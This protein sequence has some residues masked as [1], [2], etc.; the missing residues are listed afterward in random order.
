MNEQLKYQNGFHNHFSTEALPGALP[1][2]QNSPQRCAY[3]LYAEQLTGSAFTAPR[4]QN[5]RSWL[6]RIRPSVVQSAYQPLEN[7]NV[8]TAPL[9]K[10][11]ADPNQMRWDPV[12][13][14]NEPTDFIDGLFTI[15]VNG[16]A[17]T[18]AGVGVHVYTF[19]KDMTER[20][21]YN[22]DG[23]LLFVPQM[24]AIR[25]RTE[26]GDI[27]IDNGEI[28][29]IP[30]GVKFQ[31]RKAQGVEAARGYIC[32]NYGSPLELP[33]LGPIGA[34]GL[35]NPR[36]F[37]SP[38]A[39]YEDLEGDYRLVAKFSGRFW[40]SK[41]DHSPLDV[42]A[43]HGNCAP[44]KYN[45]ANFNTIN[46]VSF[47]H[48][49]PSIFTVLT[50]PSDTLGMANID[51]VIFP[52]RWMVAENTFRPPWFHRNLMSEFMGLIHGEYDAKAEGFTP[53]GASLHNSMSP[54]GPDAETFEKASNAELKPHFIGDTLAFMFESRYFFHPTPAA[55]NADFRQRDYVDVW[56]TLRSHFNPSQP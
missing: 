46:T 16:D 14:P 31:V 21:F 9:D 41:L 39:A 48:P 29:V 19:N 45:L 40:E 33:G 17:G 50:S 25:L 8:H 30:R 49:D 11:A 10:P 32:E 24:G 23:E 53:G 27:E 43:W 3:G 12:S 35:A 37:Q 52:P 13:L 6:Y 7:N 18:Q 51:F 15:A 36:D 55:L 44:Y 1:I 4:H 22:A 38:V 54:H 2:G 34:N 56:S 20:F 28:A 42:V 47:D 5:F 26:F